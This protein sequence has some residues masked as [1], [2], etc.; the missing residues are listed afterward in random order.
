[1]A[2]TPLGNARILIAGNAERTGHLKIHIQSIKDCAFLFPVPS[3]DLR[4]G[5]IRPVQSRVSETMHAPPHRGL[6]ATSSQ[7][8][9]A[10]TSSQSPQKN[11]RLATPDQ[12]STSC[13]ATSVPT[14]WRL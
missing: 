10:D 9:V 4:S 7:Y 14:A 6:L 11:T 8:L 1:M 2:D 12:Q 3:G 5:S 13:V